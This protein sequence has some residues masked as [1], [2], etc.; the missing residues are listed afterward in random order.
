MLLCGDQNQSLLGASAGPDV[1]EG[2][3]VHY[4]HI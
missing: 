1:K 4:E 3:G 2:K